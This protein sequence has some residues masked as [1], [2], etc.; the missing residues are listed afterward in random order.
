MKTQIKKGGTIIGAQRNINLIEGANITISTSENAGTK[1]VD[2]TIASTGSGSVVW[3]A[4][5]GTLSSQTDLQNAL[6]ARLTQ[7]QVEGLI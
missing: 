4:I 3:G 5:S 1:S 6:N 2:V 7:Q